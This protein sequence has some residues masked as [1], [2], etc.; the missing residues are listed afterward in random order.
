MLVDRYKGVVC[1][2][3]F[4]LTGDWRFAEVVAEDTFVSAWDQLGQPTEI[5]SLSTWLCELGRT[6]ARRG[7]VIHTAPAALDGLQSGASRQAEVDHVIMGAV[8][9]LPDDERISLDL[10]YTERCSIRD[11]SAELSRSNKVTEQRLRRRK[12]QLEIAIINLVEDSLGRMRP[13]DG[14]VA[15]VMSRIHGA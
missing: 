8:S 3:A 6:I 12:R 11:V 7:S 9:R 1:A 14:F 5:G 2:I 13:S 4:S 15:A 10:N